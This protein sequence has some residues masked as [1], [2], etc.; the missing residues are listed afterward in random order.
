MST[1]GPGPLEERPGPRDLVAA[2]RADRRGR[3]PGLDVGLGHAEVPEVLERD[4]DP[5]ARQIGRHVLDQARERQAGGQVRGER[6]QL[7]RAVAADVQQQVADRLGGLAGVR[8]QVVPG[9]VAQ[10]LEVGPEAG[11]QLDE[12]G[13]R[14]R[15]R[16]DRRR[17]RDEHRVLGRLAEVGLVQQLL[18]A[19]ELARAPALVGGLV[20]EVVGHPRE[21]EDREDVLAQVGARE[22]RRHREVVVVGAAQRLAVAVAGAD[23]ERGR[24]RDGLGGGAAVADAVDHGAGS[25]ADALKVAPFTAARTAAAVSG[26]RSPAATSSAATASI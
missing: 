7:G 18:P 12:L 19:I 23:L 15:Q 6:V 11:H 2:E 10:R 17:Q 1:S 9:R 16:L 3:A 4:V 8:A 22:D 24:Q 5:A 14:Q 26:R 20:G 13:D 21:R 25:W